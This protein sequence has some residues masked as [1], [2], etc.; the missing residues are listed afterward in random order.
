MFA[1]QHSFMQDS[2]NQDSVT[3]FP[4]KHDMA[5]DFHAAQVWTKPPK[6]WIARED[7][8][9]FFKCIKITNG[10]LFAPGLGRIIAN[11]AAPNSG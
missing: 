1:G 4:V 2:G 5:G 11:A 8:A 3:V 7:I 6:R 10:L 9:E